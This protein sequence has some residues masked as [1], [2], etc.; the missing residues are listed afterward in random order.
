MFRTILPTYML[1]C[2]SAVRSMMMM[3]MMMMMIIRQRPKQFR[4]SKFL[5]AVL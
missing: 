3:M 4:T 5:S 2:C 1:Y